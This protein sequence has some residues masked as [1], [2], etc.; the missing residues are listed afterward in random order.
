LSA[1]SRRVLSV[2]RCLAAPL[3]SVLGSQHRRQWLGVSRTDGR[4][5]PL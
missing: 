5:R 3:E 4:G 1:I 2:Q